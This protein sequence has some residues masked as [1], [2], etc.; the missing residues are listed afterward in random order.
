[1]RKR[2]GEWRKWPGAR[3]GESDD[4]GESMRFPSL[5]VVNNGDGDD[6][7]AIYRHALAHVLASTFG[8]GDLNL[9]RVCDL[10]ARA[11]HTLA[12]RMVSPL[13]MKD[14]DRSPSEL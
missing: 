1:M 3:V 2:A 7:E 9:S 10:Y 6:N 11:A 8:P 12:K 5:R 4:R 14:L 13:A